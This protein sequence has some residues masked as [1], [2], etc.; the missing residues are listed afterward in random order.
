LKRIAIILAAMLLMFMSACSG[1]EAQ[2][3]DK[4]S[5]KTAVKEEQDK[6]KMNEKANNVSEKDKETSGTMEDAAGQASDGN[7]ASEP[8]LAVPAYKMNTDFSIKSIKNPAE[9]VVL[10][11]IDDAP[12]KHSLSMAKTLKDLNVK[13]IF[14][15]NGHF[16]D[17]P[18]EGEVLRQIHQM[19]FPIG[20]HTYSHKSLKEL[21]EEQQKAEIV[22]LN[23][24]IEEL[25]GERPKFFRAPFGINTEYSKKLAAEEK[26]LV[27]NWTYGY[28]WEKDFQSS[29]AL[30]DIMVNTPL[31]HSGANLLMHD[32]E[33][34][35]AA[36][37]GIVQGLQ[38]KGYTIVDPNL[39]QT[40]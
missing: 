5:S 30:A 24:R 34:T 20:N 39:I 36:L 15:V 1:K 33:W 6:G 18:E 2:E 3:A 7:E 8:A 13:A 31:L 19:G 12:D 21:T 16:I 23:N 10:L 28:D 37:P 29:E 17:T 27:M 11:T 9:R 26:M 40:P 4:N 35:S 38:N 32:R 25:I 14:F 22:G